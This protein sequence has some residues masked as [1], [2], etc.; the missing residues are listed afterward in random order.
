M[1]VRSGTKPGLRRRGRNNVFGMLLLSIAIISASLILGRRPINP[2]QQAAVAPVV[3]QF[4]LVQ[5]P[6]PNEPVPV[7]VKL[8]TV[9]FTN[10]AFPKHQIPSGA[11]LDLGPYVD[12]VTVAPLPAKLPIF[13]E[14]VSQTAGVSNPV[15]ERIPKGMRAMTIKVDAMSAVEGWAGSGS[16]VDV[17]LIERERTIV[18]AETVKILSAERSVSPVEGSAAP[19]LPSTVTLLV[20]Q[21]QCLAINTAIPRGRIAFALRSTQDTMQWDSTSYTADRLRGGD[22]LTAP[23]ESITGFVVVGSGS[24]AKSFALAGDKWTKTEVIPQGFLV[25]GKKAEHEKS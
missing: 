23:P 5:I 11:L 8:S 22:G 10:I 12:S 9:S 16:V 7:G 20:T 18:I 19:K 13:R 2:A 3:A 6:V 25:A 24:D 1:A 17:L 4:D 14:N 15:V 21:E